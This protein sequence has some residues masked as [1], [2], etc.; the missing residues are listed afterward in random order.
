MLFLLSIIFMIIL[1]FYYQ[2]NHKNALYK[3]GDSSFK[4]ITSIQYYETKET[5][6]L[7][8]GKHIKSSSITYVYPDK[9]RIETFGSSK[10]I[11]IYNHNKYFFYDNENNQTKYKE[12]FPPEKPYITE[13]EKKMVNILNKGEYEFFGYEERDNKRMEVIGIKSR[14][15]GHSY[16]HKLWI[17]NFNDIILPVKEEYFIDNVVVSK[18]TYAFQKVNEA[19]DPVLFESSSIHGSEVKKDGYLPKFVNTIE[20]AKKYLNFKPI[21]P[22]TSPAGFIVS[23]ISVIPPVKSPSFNCIYFSEGRRIYLTEKVETENI[24]GNAVLGNK[25]CIY[26]RVDG[27]VN[28]KWKEGNIVITLQGAEELSSEIIGIAEMIS[29]GNL[30]K[31]QH[32]N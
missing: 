3:F 1:I 28:I 2:N 15:D 26:E 20:D 23:E 8:D 21:I 5:Y 11:E 32:I 25:S 17:T 10:R 30:V 6:G 18:T 31:T 22:N 13:I 16:M 7:G 4:N 12:C 24:I 9:L 27:S 19:I 14:M 29:G